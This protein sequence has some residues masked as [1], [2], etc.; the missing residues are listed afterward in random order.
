MGKAGLLVLTVACEAQGPQ[1]RTITCRNMGGSQVAL[2]DMEEQQTIATLRN[3][4]AEQLQ[5]HGHLRLVRCDCMLLNDADSVASV[6]AVPMAD[7]GPSGGGGD[8]QVPTDFKTWLLEV[9]EDLKQE[10]KEV[11]EISD[12][13]EARLNE[14]RKAETEILNRKQALIRKQSALQHRYMDVV[15]HLQGYKSDEE[16]VALVQQAER[17]PAN[18]SLPTHRQPYQQAWQQQAYS[19]ACPQAYAA[20]GK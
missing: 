16:L 10:A 18:A 2:L 14:Q 13:Y 4:L 5:F 15:S 8:P 6:R 20:T 9:L 19:Q 1:Q 3:A 12:L 11:Q 7:G 17:R